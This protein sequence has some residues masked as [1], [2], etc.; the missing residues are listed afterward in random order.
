MA[1]VLLLRLGDG[2]EAQQWQ[3][4]SI[5]LSGFLLGA[6]YGMMNSV[7][8]VYLFGVLRLDLWV[9]GVVGMTHVLMDSLVHLSARWVKKF[10]GV[11]EKN[12]GPCPIDTSVFC[13]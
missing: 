2:V 3:I 11:A 5:L 9:L 13:L 6:V 1:V 8:F 12:K 10:A 4:Q 7:L